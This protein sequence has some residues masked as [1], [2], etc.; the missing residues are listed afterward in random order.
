[1]EKVNEPSRRL[2]WKVRIENDNSNQILIKE[3]WIYNEK[4]VRV[5]EEIKKV[6]IKKLW[7]EKWQVEKELKEE[8]YMCQRMRNWE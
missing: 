4:I 2:D 7:G 1:M 5:V 8:K 6:G 3:Q